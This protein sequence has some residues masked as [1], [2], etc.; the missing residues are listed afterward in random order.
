[1]IFQV[2]GKIPEL[3]QLLRMFFSNPSSINISDFLLK[4]ENNTLQSE[5]DALSID[6]FKNITPELL[7]LQT[8]YL[9]FSDEWYST[10]KIEKN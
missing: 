1:M 5:K 8:W 4:L 2:I 7:L 9:T 10:L 6:S 3:L